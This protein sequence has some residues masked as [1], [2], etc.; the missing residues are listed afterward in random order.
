MEGVR[1]A[2]PDVIAA[3]PPCKAHSTADMQNRSA[4]PALIASTREFI[5]ASGHVG[6]IENVKGA[7]REMSSRSALLYGSYFGL[8]VDR[9]R[10]MEGCGFDLRVD[11]YLRGPGLALRARSCLGAR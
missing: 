10:F 4:A 1:W 2:R 3:S 11:D 5:R 8:R 9:P 7:S 6:Y